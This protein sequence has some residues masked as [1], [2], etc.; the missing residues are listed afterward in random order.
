VRKLTALFTIA[1]TLLSISSLPVTATDAQLPPGS[2]MI[3]GSAHSFSVSPPLREMDVCPGTSASVPSRV[4]ARRTLTV[5]ELE[6]IGLAEIAGDNC[7]S[8]PQRR[9]KANSR[10][11]QVRT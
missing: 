9:R 1:V 11:R 8:A 4:E 6:G 10:E 3:V 5:P 2:N 7:N